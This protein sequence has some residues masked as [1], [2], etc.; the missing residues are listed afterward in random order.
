MNR[1]I[2]VLAILCAG[3]LKENGPSGRTK[4]QVISSFSEV[5]LE[6]D[7]RE[8]AYETAHNLTLMGRVFQSKPIYFVVENK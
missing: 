1:S 6:T 4:Y 8:K 7:E 2:L 5:V 3:C